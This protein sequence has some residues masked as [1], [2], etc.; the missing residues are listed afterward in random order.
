MQYRQY[1]HCMWYAVNI[2]VRIR[3]K[4]RSKTTAKE[5]KND[6][7]KSGKMKEKNKNN[8]GE[9]EEEEEVIRGTECG[10]QNKRK[11]RAIDDQVR[12][13]VREREIKSN[14]KKEKLTIVTLFAG[15]MY[16]II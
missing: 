4:K 2:R 10:D 3:I 12:D 1:M 6:K 11:G 9:K 15:H 7:R 13:R 8:D 5:S 14:W 16:T